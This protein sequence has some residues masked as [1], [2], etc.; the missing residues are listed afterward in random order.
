MK[1]T[2]STTS[3]GKLAVCF[4]SENAGENA[5]ISL[6]H[7][8]ASSTGCKV[9]P[10][11]N[12]Q[13]SL[14]VDLTSPGQTVPAFLAQACIRIPSLTAGIEQ[15]FQIWQERGGMS[16]AAGMPAQAVPAG[17]PLSK[18]IKFMQLRAASADRQRGMEIAKL[19]GAVGK[20]SVHSVIRNKIASYEVIRDTYENAIGTLRHSPAKQA[21]ILNDIQDFP[22]ALSGNIATEQGHIRDFRLSPDMYLSKNPF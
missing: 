9:E 14:K 19:P 7:A 10:A 15:A 17:A 11:V 13:A 12:P 18:L 2:P 16:L 1:V 22:G 20:E 3:T 6:L 5:S 4:K 21:T 8:L